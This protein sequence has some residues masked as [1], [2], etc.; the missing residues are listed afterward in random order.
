MNYFGIKLNTKIFFNWEKVE[1]SLFGINFVFFEK[2]CLANTTPDQAGHQVEGD[3]IFK[4]FIILNKILIL[5]KILLL[6]KKYFVV[7]LF[8]IYK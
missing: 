4:F 8:K 7:I 2:K 3:F 1:K 5:L 6:F